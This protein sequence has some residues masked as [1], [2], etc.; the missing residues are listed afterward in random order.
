[1][2]GAIVG[3]MLGL[4]NRAQWPVPIRSQLYALFVTLRSI[5]VALDAPGT[6]QSTA[7]LHVAL[8]GCLGL[9]GTLL[10][11]VRKADTWNTVDRAEAA[12]FDRDLPILRVAQ[13]AREKRAAKAWTSA[14]GA[15][16]LVA[17]SKL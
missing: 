2:N 5:V 4:S 1:M 16:G 11:S 3:Y 7:R 13:K 6:T 15:S 12:R 8:D 14:G 10:T 17:T 9:F